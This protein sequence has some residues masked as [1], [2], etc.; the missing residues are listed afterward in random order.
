MIFWYKSLA[1]SSSKRPE[2]FY[3]ATDRRRCRVSQLNIRQSSGSPAE[4]G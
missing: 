2:R 1:E 3:L 4:E